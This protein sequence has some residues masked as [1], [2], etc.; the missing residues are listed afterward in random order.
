MDKI[1]SPEELVKILNSIPNVIQEEVNSGMEKATMIVE[2]RA[3]L[4]CH[5]SSTPYYRAPHI[6][7]TLQASITG[8][9][10]HDNGSIMGIIYVDSGH[11]NPMS[12]SSVM[13]YAPFV[14]DGTSKMPARPFMLDAINFERERVVK[15]LSDSVI[16]ALKRVRE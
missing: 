3:K 15:I 9:V 10:E 13:E 11:T 5:P 16:N 8:I 12:Q 6:T 14:H 4:N 1:I 7:G 2:R